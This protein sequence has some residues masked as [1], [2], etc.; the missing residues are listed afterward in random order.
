M[1]G[2]LLALQ[3]L[4]ELPPGR[5]GRPREP[6]LSALVEER[7]RVGEVELSLRRPTDPE[8]L[9]DEE[10]FADDEF[11]PYWAE[12]W[13][14][15]L[16]LARGAAAEPGRRVRRR[17]RVRA[18]R[19]V[20]RGGC[21]RSACDS[22]GLGRGCDRVAPR[23]RRPQRP[24]ARGDVH[25]LAAIRGKL[26]P[27]ARGRRALRAAKRR[28]ARGAAAPLAPEALVAL[29]GRPYEAEFLAAVESEP[30]AERVV[31]IRPRT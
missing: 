14:A 10:A 9:L 23:E 26:R 20:A 8:A 21:E 27:R 12:L 15:G 13:P 11:L 17:A 31:R 4:G 6:A 3:K 25:R 28:A 2:V 18:R 22:D 16:A 29:A 24:G 30:V 19:A 7:I 5:H 1:P